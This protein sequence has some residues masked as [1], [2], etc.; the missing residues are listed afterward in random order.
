MN[1]NAGQIAVVVVVVLRTVCV[2]VFV[3]LAHEPRIVMVVALRRFMH[4]LFAFDCVILPLALCVC[5][6]ERVLA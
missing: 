2:F 5:E 4:M 3:L 6:R 1:V